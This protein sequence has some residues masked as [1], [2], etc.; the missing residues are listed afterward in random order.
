M[1]RL[2]FF[3]VV[4]V[5]SGASNS[6]GTLVAY[7]IIVSYSA[8]NLFVAYVLFFAKR[9]GNSKIKYFYFYELNNKSYFFNFMSQ[10]LEFFYYL[11]F[12]IFGDNASEQIIMPLLCFIAI[13][14]ALF[15]FSPFQHWW[16]NLVSLMESLG[17]AASYFLF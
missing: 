7:T 11:Y 12:G 9:G 17:Y 3:A 5:F 14:L 16:E 13:S 4:D 6:I 2:F 10:M 1:I 8:F 15:L